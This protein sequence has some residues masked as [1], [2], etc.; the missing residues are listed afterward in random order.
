MRKVQKQEILSVIDGF[1]QAHEEIL[2]AL[3]SGNNALVRNMLSE[4]QELAIQ[5]GNTIESLEG[6]GCVAVTYVEEY[7]E[8]LFRVFEQISC[9]MDQKEIYR[10]LEK[11]INQIENSVRNDICIKREVVF[12]PYKASMWDSLESVYL[13]AKADP[14]CDAYCVPIPYYDRNPDRSFGQ[15]HYEG[16]EYPENIEV[17]DWQAY[18]FEER[19]PDMVFIH[20]PY[21]HCNFVTSVHP[22]FYSENL[23]KYAEELIYIPYFLSGEI[24][25]EDQD[26]IDRMK[27]FIFLPG[28][29]NAD[30]VIVQSK[31]MEQ[32]YIKE[33]QKAAGKAGLAAEYLDKGH[34]EQ[35]FQG[36]GS[37]KLDKVRTTQREGV[38]I[39]E[40]WRNIL[41][42][43]DGSRRN[44]IFYNTSIQA[45]LDN[46]ETMLEKIQQ[47]L[48]FFRSRQEEIALLWRPHPLIQA[49]IASLR[50]QLW[51]KYQKIVE[52]YRSEG[53]G[54]YDDSP[55]VDR[56][57]ILCDGY[58][59]DGSSVVSLCKSAGKPVMIQDAEIV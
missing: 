38:E 14:G 18:R 34:L 41:W 28:V 7:C 40:S 4:C 46:G 36:L 1:R 10:G 26:T 59:G 31:K 37:P 29:I 17:T 9:N 33:Y 47:V 12:F 8:F 42:K 58:F 11:Q 56:A 16:G 15:M 48:Q 51:K 25:P 23:K 21:D 5:I 35:K 3:V 22:R 49:T 44:V 24:E 2:G 43:A 20:N 52:Q 55:D 39:P 54:I 13:A 45:L 53:W 50:P 6:E 57:V 27:H 19:K 32:I 30:K